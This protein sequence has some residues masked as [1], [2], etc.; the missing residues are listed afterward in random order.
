M[1]FPLSFTGVLK[2]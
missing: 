2:A 1:T